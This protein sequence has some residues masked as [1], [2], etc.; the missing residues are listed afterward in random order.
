MPTSRRIG[1][2]YPDANVR[3]WVDQFESLIASLDAS[4]YAAREDRNILVAGGAPLEISSTGSVSWGSELLVFYGSRGVSGTLPPGSVDLDEGEIAYV[5]LVRYP[6]GQHELALNTTTSSAPSSDSA[7]VL[8]YRSDDG[9]W[10]RDSG[11]HELGSLVNA[12]YIDAIRT[13]ISIVLN[14]TQ[15]EGDRALGRF[16]V[17]PDKYQHGSF[18][19]IS[20]YRCEA[21]VTGDLLGGTVYLYDVTSG[22]VL[23]DSFDVVTD[24]PFERTFPFDPAGPGERVYEVRAGLWTVGQPKEI[25]IS[26]D[27]TDT[28][29][30]VFRDVDNSIDYTYTGLSGDTAGDIASGLSG[31]ISGSARFSSSSAGNIVT[32]TCLSNGDDFMYDLLVDAGGGL[33]SALGDEAMSDSVERAAAKD[34]PYVEDE[35]ILVWHAT[36]ELI[37]TASS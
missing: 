12:S 10:V 31:A 15:G 18:P 37:A 27:S 5:D 13:P 1:H 2:P 22:D 20:S 26:I 36:L 35:L 25:T 29:D 6:G 34:A 8:F 14:E 23:I 16:R 3:D 19:V 17:D 21:Q 7:L 30:Y 32:V 24:Q 4:D 11:F 33:D 28:Y 9:V